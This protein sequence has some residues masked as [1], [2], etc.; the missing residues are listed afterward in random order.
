MCVGELTIIVSDNV[1]SH[2]RCQAI[3]WNN[4]GILLIGPLVTHFNEILIVIY[5][6]S[7][8]KMHLKMSSGK[9]RPFW[10]DLSV[11]LALIARR[12]GIALAAVGA[13]A[14]LVS[15]RFD[16][17]ATGCLIVVLTGVWLWNIYSTSARPVFQWVVG[18]KLGWVS[19]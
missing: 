5:T 19:G 9:W 18:D 16:R 10:L 1:L 4:A 3:I 8:K 14:W 2:G 7:F 17:T 13:A 11:L 15:I 12:P 6:S